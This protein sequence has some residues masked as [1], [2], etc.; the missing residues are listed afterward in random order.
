MLVGAYL[1][2]S[3]A[4]ASQLVSDDLLTSSNLSTPWES[5]GV[6]SVAIDV[7]NLDAGGCAYRTTPIE[8]GVTYKMSCGVKVAKYASMYCSH[9]LNKTSVRVTSYP[10]HK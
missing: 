2:G 9:K 8:A 1:V 7:S 10:F 4:S 5:C 6:D 3:T